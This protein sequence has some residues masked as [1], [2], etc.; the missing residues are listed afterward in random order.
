LIAAHKLGRRCFGLEL[1]PLYC[2]VICQRFLD[3][4]GIEPVLEATGEAFSDLK[5][6][7]G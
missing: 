6:R 2:D 7:H 1:E 5:A 3:F 4:T